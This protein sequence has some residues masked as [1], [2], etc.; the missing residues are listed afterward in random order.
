MHVYA[1]SH[2][3]ACINFSQYK[4]KVHWEKMWLHWKHLRRWG[5]E[6]ESVARNAFFKFL[7][8]EATIL[9]FSIPI[10]INICVTSL[11]KCN[12]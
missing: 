9:T 6:N 7:I 12:V 4:Q 3:F 11:F 10:T 5:K 2:T 1:S 8:E